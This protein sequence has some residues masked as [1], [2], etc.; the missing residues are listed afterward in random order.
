[1]ACFPNGSMKGPTPE[2]T[3]TS[4]SLKSATLDDGTRVVTS[5][6]TDIRR[7]V[8]AGIDVHKSVLMAAVCKTDPRTLSAVFYVRP[9]TSANSDVRRMADWMKGYGVQDVCMESTGKYWIPV[10]DILDQNG[11]KPILTHP[12]SVKQAK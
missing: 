4:E 9:F 2:K 5:P 1:M 11:L 10:Y 12:K 3:Y 8:C 6:A 7:P